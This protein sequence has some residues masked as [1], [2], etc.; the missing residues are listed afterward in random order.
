MK[1]F[2]FVT[3]S[4]P[5]TSGEGVEFDDG[6]AVYRNRVNGGQPSMVHSGSVAEIVSRYAEHE[7]FRL[8]WLDSD[9]SEEE[10]SAARKRSAKADATA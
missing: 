10:A 8:T 5:I 9:P 4:H 2:T 7:N 6:R 1:R 3:G